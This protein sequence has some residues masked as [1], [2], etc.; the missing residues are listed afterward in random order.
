[1]PMPER[2][3]KPWELID[4]TLRHG[5]IAGELAGQFVGADIND[6]AQTTNRTVISLFNDLGMFAS[7]ISMH[8]E[9]D[10]AVNPPRRIVEE[11]LQAM[12]TFAGDVICN[13]KTHA[14]KFFSFTHAVPPVSTFGLWPIRFPVKSEFASEFLHFAIGTLIEIAENSC[15]GF[16][17]NLDPKSANCILEPLYEWKATLM[18]QRFAI[19]VPGEISQAELMKLYETIN[20][21]NPFYPD[22]TTATPSKEATAEVKTGMDVLSWVPTEADWTQFARIHLLR[23]RPER[24]LQPEATRQTTEDVI[25]PDATAADGTAVTQGPNA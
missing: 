10:V 22:V 24:I 2:F 17:K 7:S 18:K 20:T 23:Y 12:M 11:C 5:G 16:H 4:P 1:M 19:E 15:N 9:A 25:S 14:T 13:T 6:N 21:P 8:P 3:T